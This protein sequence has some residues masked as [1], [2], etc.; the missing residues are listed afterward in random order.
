MRKSEDSFGWGNTTINSVC[1]L[2]CPDACSLA[3]TLQRGKILKIDGSNQQATT[4][5]YICAKVRRF[6]ERVYGNDRLHHPVVRN[7]SRSEGK[8]KRV[9]WDEALDTIAERITNIKNRWGAEAILPFS[10]GGSN[11]LLSQDTTDA[12]LFRLLGTSRLARTVC[13]APTSA[14]SQAL[15]GKMPGV[16]Y[17][18]YPHAQLII[19]WGVNPSTSGIHLVRYIR[20][21][22]KR[23]ALLVVIDPR[24]TPLAHQADLHLAVKPGTDLPVA[25]AI[26]RYLFENELVDEKFIANHTRGSQQLRSRAASWTISRAAQVADIDPDDLRR[27]ADLYATSSPAVIRCGWGVERNRNGGNAVLSILSLPAVCG[28]FGVRGGGYTMSNKSALSLSSNEWINAKEPTTRVINMNHLGRAL[29]DFDNPPIKMLFVYNCN[30]AV[31][32]PD[33]NRVIKGL[34]R[35]DLFTIVFDQVMTDT[36]RLAD[37]VLPATTFL[38]SYDVV[39]SYGPI[40]LQLARPVIDTVEE[41]RPNVEVF[42]ELSRRL[43]L[44][45]ETQT[46][47]ELLLD[48]VEKMPTNISADLLDKGIVDPPMD[49]C[50]I[51][52]SHVFPRTTDKKVDLFPEQLA[53]DNEIELYTYQC[54]PETTQYPLALIS[55]ASDKTINSILGELRDKLA[56][57]QICPSDAGVRGIQQGDTVRI[58]NDLGE[59]HCHVDIETGMRRG[60][61]SLPK[62]LW[63]KS[64]LNGSTANALVPDSLTDLGR[65]ACFNDA[66]VEVTRMIT[67][68]YQDEN[69]SLWISETSPHKP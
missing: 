68:Q 32:M 11:G 5:G 46:D 62:G 33:Q 28:K 23:G 16:S 61:V 17:E 19:L 20:E 53:A 27:L 38:E 9:G 51:Q 14:A 18:D 69:V 47:A 59:V 26:H 31:T 49:P 12:Q 52:F 48:V 36:A 37:M 63:Q 15:Y 2:D 13:A 57:L 34:Q 50:P 30:P 64:T 55:P 8:F 35:D 4:G 54:G 21:A 45:S 65:G 60:T 22:Q 24:R 3:V 6:D 66:R 1:T 67:A 10:Y 42:N 25:L 58:F 43:N 29:L 44:V 41:S 7:G 39:Q 40:S 56:R